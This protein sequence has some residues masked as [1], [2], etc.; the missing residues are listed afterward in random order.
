MTRRRIITVCFLWMTYY[1]NKNILIRLF[2]ELFIYI[3]TNKKLQTTMSFFLFIF[4]VVTKNV[5]CVGVRLL[6]CTRVKTCIRFLFVYKWLKRFKL[7]ILC[8]T[9]IIKGD[10]VSIS[11]MINNT[12]K[13]LEIS[14]DQI[15]QRYQL[16]NILLTDP[17]QLIYE[18]LVFDFWINGSIL[19]LV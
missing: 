1:I 19:F 3:Y 6:W 4:C 8:P 7:H 17:V 15:Y 2:H 9:I 16:R 10:I 13:N 11:K 18:G 5:F 12:V 14:H